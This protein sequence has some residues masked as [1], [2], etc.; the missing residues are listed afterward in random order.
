MK[1]LLIIAAATLAA[2]GC[3]AVRD[4]R[5]DKNPYEKPFYAKYLN[6]GSAVD[7][8]ILRTL[9]ALR[10]DASAPELHNALGALLIEKGFPK[11]AER[12][13]ERAIDQR[14]RYYPAWYN[15]GLV[16]ASLGD[17]VGAR[18][19]FSRTVTLKPGHAA[20]LFQLGLIEEKRAH[21]DRAID[22]YA[23]AFTINPAL[24]QVD[25]NPRVLDTHLA[26]LALLKAYPTTH[27]R[28]SMQ[29]QEATAV[30]APVRPQVAA[31]PAPSP[32]APATKIVVPAPAPQKPAK[33]AT[34]T[35]RAVTPAAPSPEPPA[36]DIVPP[37]PPPT[38]ASQQSAPIAVRTA[39]PGSKPPRP[40]RPRKDET[41]KE[42]AKPPVR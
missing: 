3:A 40:V 31:P 10:E 9:D 22:L 18:R 1:R 8:Q 42:P 11:D 34:V 26:H 39:A 20:A 23:K 5:T 17:N 6:T 41:E 13:F 33:P 37:A 27:A 30:P 25:V 35:P 7:A 38:D 21:I 14:G 24:M 4:L 12:E 2:T 32:Q 36:K 16:R 29:F 19:A 15:L 28:Y